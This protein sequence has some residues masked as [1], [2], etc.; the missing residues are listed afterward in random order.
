MHHPTENF[1]HPTA[2][3]EG[4]VRIGVGNYIGP[5]AHISGPVVIGDNNWIGSNVRIGA[6]PEVKSINH[7]ESATSADVFGVRIGNNAVI[8]EAAQIHQ[9]WKRETLIGSGSFIMNQVYIAHDCSIGENSTIASSVLLAGNVTL[10]VMANLGLGTTVHQGRNIGP[11]AMVGMASVI[12]R[13]VPAF[14]KCFGSPAQ[15]R[16]V[17]L[18]G[19]QRAGIA[20]EQIEVISKFLSHQSKFEETAGSMVKVLSASL[21]QQFGIS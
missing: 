17:N 16:G 12:T 20:G 21:C 14:S 4:D 15:V 19:M 18:I 2:I 13:D 7:F 11:L 3:L 9:G 1:I 10:G 6:I 8:R 5:F